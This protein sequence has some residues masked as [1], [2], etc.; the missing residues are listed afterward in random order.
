[1][2]TEVTQEAP[3]DIIERDRALTEIQDKVLWLSMQMVYHA[4][5]VRP[6]PDEG[7]VGGHQ[8]SSS[9]IVTLMTS[10]FFDFMDAGD[11]ISVK[12]HASPVFHAIQYLLGNLDRE[13]LT[14]LRAFHGTSGVPQ[15]HEGPRSR[16][17]SPPARWV[18]A[19]SRP[20]SRH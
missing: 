1:M 5:E 14:Q 20:T 8:A 3:A 4:N 11:R 9:S 7:K 10:L 18:L 16:S 17:T 15:P 13:Y 19:R 6:S 2:A 12:P